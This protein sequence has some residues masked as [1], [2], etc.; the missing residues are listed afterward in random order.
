MLQKN[1]NSPLINKL[2][3]VGGILGPLTT[4]PQLYKIWIGKNASGVSVISWGAYAVGSAFWVWYGITN[5]QRPL[6]FT[7]SLFLV[8]E[9]MIIIGTFLYGS[10]F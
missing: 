6:V 10:G 7:Y 9:I 3:Y 1:S 4:I 5:K 2:I 8:V